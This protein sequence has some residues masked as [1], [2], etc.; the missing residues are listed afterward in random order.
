MVQDAKTRESQSPPPRRNRSESIARGAVGLSQD[1]FARAGFRD[2]ALVLRWADIA[3]PEVARLCQPLKLSDGPAGG[4]L[5][6]KAEP[7]AAIFLQHE[8]RALCE[9]I[10][11]W[12]GR[13]AITRLRFVQGPLAAPAKAK[14]RRPSSGEIQPDDP[15]LAY[16]GPEPVREALIKLARSR[17]GRRRPD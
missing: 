5:T 6:L 2:P 10:N 16:N 8:S 11:R 13:E 12:L 4:V 7:G 14:P 3:G 1:I 9:R 17:S 15:A